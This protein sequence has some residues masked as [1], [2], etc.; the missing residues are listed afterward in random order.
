MTSRRPSQRCRTNDQQRFT[1]REAAA[2]SLV[3]R[4]VVDPHS[5][6]DTMFALLR[7]HFSEEEII[8]LVLRKQSFTW[9]G[10]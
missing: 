1:P 4:L 2:I 7:I 3:D 5:V 10:A 6:D 8:E 9:A